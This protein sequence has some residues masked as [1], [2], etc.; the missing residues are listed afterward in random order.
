MASL[1]LS[2]FTPFFVTYPLCYQLELIYQFISL[3]IIS[4][5][6]T[7]RRLGNFCME[8]TGRIMI[9]LIQV[10][11]AFSV[12]NQEQ[13]PNNNEDLLTKKTIIGG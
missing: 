9:F 12:W 5:Y 8:Y 4:G 2:F 13:F 7:F 6:I 1:R 11:N 3:L 10:T